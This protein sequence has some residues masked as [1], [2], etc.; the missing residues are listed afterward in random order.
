MQCDSDN[1]ASRLM[2]NAISINRQINI[3]IIEM[4]EKKNTRV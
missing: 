4:N 2:G 1:V 3:K